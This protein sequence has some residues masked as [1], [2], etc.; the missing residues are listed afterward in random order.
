MQYL[1]IFLVAAVPT[2]IIASPRP[3]NGGY[4]DSLML[5]GAF[6]GLDQSFTSGGDLITSQANLLTTDEH[7]LPFDSTSLP[8]VGGDFI[9][10]NAD[11]SY[12]ILSNDDPP[13]YNEYSLSTDGELY[14]DETQELVQDGVTQYFHRLISECG[15]RPCF[16]DRGN[17][18]GLERDYGCCIFTYEQPDTEYNMGVGGCKNCM[19]D[20][21]S[22]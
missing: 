5:D 13:V 18:P 21:I 17:N 19:S 16:P 2:T 14:A 15:E 3:D 7:D 9:A 1:V 20:L 11:P 4:Q 22:K 12:P 6:A 8:V 10:F